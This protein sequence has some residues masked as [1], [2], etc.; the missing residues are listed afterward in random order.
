MRNT[1]KDLQNSHPCFDGHKNHAGQIHLPVS[2]GCN[3]A[4]RF[5]DRA[6]NDVE[7]RPGVTSK[8]EALEKAI[9]ICPEIKV[10][11]IAGPGGHTGIGSRV[12]NVPDRG[13]KIPRSHQMYE[14]ERTAPV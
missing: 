5:C 3:I 4:C 7:D 13:G 8:V 12:G 1:Y 6:I 11:G 9:L 10:A 2:P 14:Y